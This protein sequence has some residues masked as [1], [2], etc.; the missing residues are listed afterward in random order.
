[1]SIHYHRAD[2]YAR[3]PTA[4]RRRREPVARHVDHPG[5]ANLAQLD[6]QA[7]RDLAMAHPCPA[8]HAP[9]GQPCTRRPRIG[10]GAG[11]QPLGYMCHP[12]R[13]ELV[14]GA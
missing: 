2:G 6:R 12:Q 1:M 10:E 8:C 4:P 7:K 14:D 13:H 9:K 5:Q 11:R 3:R